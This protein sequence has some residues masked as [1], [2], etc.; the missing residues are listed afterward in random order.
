MWLALPLTALQYWRVWDALPARLATH[1]DAHWN[2]NGWMTR[3]VSLWFSL[4]L[5][6]FLLA[7]FTTV[8]LVAHWK[9]APEP[10][11]WV[12]L[13]FF[14]VVL[15]FVIAVNEVVLRYNLDGRPINLAQI[16]WVIP[17][18][19]L[20]MIF[21]YLRV[22]RG[23]PLPASPVLAEEVHTGR[24]WALVFVLPLAVLV[25]VGVSAPNLGLRLTMSLIG[26]VLVAALAMAR[27]GFHYRFTPDGVEIS[28]LGYR[29]R[30]IPRR[31]IREYRVEPWNILGGYGIRGVG[32]S[33]AYVWGNR[34]VHIKTAEGEVYL[35]HSEP[36]RIVQDL[37]TMMKFAH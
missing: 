21:V 7:T 33:R 17:V 26:L 5:T 10:F 30:S 3:E 14:Y 9:K 24:A 32:G 4:G 12:L 29:L 20:A 16:M 34:V 31:Q 22:H 28:T 35:G 8:T 23:M 13:A 25:I 27:S 2:P 11:S 15:G 37:D 36:Q 19:I 1:F 18:A 6:V